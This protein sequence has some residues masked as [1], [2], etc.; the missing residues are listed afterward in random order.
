VSSIAICD[1]NCCAMLDKL[2]VSQLVKK[3]PA[4]CEIQRFITVFVRAGHLPLS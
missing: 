3:F 1:T 4:V 2:I